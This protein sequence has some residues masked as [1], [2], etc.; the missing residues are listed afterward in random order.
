METLHTE[1]RE[2]IVP[3]DE[4]SWLDMRAKDITSTEAAVLFGCSPYLTLY[5]LWHRKKEQKVVTLAANE[6]MKWGNRLQDAI[7]A[8]V[9]EDEKWT[10]RKMKEYIRLP[11]LRMGSSF[12]FYRFPGK[13]GEA[14]MDFLD[15]ELLEIKN[16]DSLAFRDGWM[17]TD[18]SLEAPLHIEFQV[19]HQLA[20]SGLKACTLAALVGGNRKV[21]IRRE[22]DEKAIDAIKREVAAFWKSIEEGIA[23]KPDFSKDAEFIVKQYGFADPGKVL[24]AEDNA[25]LKRLAQEYTALG[26]AAKDADERKKAVKAQLLP[27]LGDAEKAYGDGFTISAGLIGPKTV[28]YT[29]DGYRDFRVFWKKT[30]Q[31]EESAR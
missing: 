10:I 7:A 24:H 12:D 26:R 5:E 28:S 31:A 3:A 29:A 23:P 18:D 19:Q 21:L 15:G 27:L 11:D 30:K 13:P 25:E 17:E 8:G 16:V 14:S 1:K 4:Q 22:R 6:R 2:S 9:A 20:V